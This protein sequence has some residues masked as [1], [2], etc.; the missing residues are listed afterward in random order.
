MSS[1]NKQIVIGIALLLAALFFGE[2]VFAQALELQYPQL[3]QAQLSQKPLLPDFIKYLYVFSVLSAGFLSVGS[4]VYGG[5]KYLSSGGSP[6]ARG[7]ARAQITGGVLGSVILLAGYILLSTINPQLTIFAIAK[8]AAQIPPVA[9]CNCFNPVTEQCKQEC[10]REELENNFLEIP[11][12]TLIEKVLNQGRLN[13][14]EKIAKDLEEK[15]TKNVR[16]KTREL[17]EELDQCQ[18]SRETVIP[19][20]TGEERGGEFECV[21][22]QCSGEPCD[23]VAVER[24]EAELTAALD[25]LADYVEANTGV[26]ITIKE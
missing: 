5:V 18:C 22:L 24:K 26:N 2:A 21:A 10:K 13:E 14:F 25:E 4:A 7:E 11:I 15:Y 3:P 6:A 17:K 12:G 9:T 1:P 8:P 16:D 20:C 23:R 19:G